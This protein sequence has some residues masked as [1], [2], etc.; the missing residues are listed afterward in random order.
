MTTTDPNRI[1]WEA[2]ARGEPTDW[3]GLATEPDGVD[4]E[5]VGEP[6]GLWLRPRGAPA[7]PV[8]LAVHGGGFVSASAATHRRMFGHLARASGVPAFVVE[9]GLVPEHVF[10]D[11]LDAVTRA[12][13]WLLH[14]GATRVALAGDSC[15]A[16]LALALALR[17]RDSGIAAPAALL[18][19]SAWTDL[20][21]TG[22]SYDRGSEPF[23]TREV[24]RGLGAGYL[25]GADPRDPLAAPAHADVRRLPATYLQV[26][27]EE[28]LLDDS[29]RLATRMRDAGVEV[30]LD[31][32]AGQLH[33]FPMAAGRTA[34]A[35]EAIARGG[36]WLR[37]K[38]VP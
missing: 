11:Q 14:R 2:V 7:G 22:G 1:H 5:R 28:S 33:S 35:D 32:F 30:R 19:I 31:E 26:G 25:A 16:G 10:P 12:Y 13:R 34:A 21:A 15:G 38:L 4:Q 8:V 6:D 27:A 9:Y 36:S 23:F 29:R 24:V 3:A 17:A 37:S 20:E 18:L